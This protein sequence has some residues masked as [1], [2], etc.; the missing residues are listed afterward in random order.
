MNIYKKIS[1]IILLLLGFCFG[2][3][4]KMITKTGKTTFEASVPSFE[5]IKATNSATTAII[6]ADTG[7]VAAVVL[8]NGF[9]FKSALM[10]EHFNEN[11]MDSSKFPKATFKGKIANFAAIK[12][13]GG[14]A[15][16]V[17][18]LDM[19][20]K[21][22]NITSEAMLTKSGAGYNLDGGFSVKPQ[23]FDI[24]I[25]TLVSK[26]IAKDIKVDYQYQLK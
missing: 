5:E 11:Y 24:E 13:K 6:N 18:V 3:S 12:D 14:K 23:D 22:K 15:A 10:E 16:I 2:F 4:Q 1:A 17:G 21:Q 8:M 25:P 20:G 26:K 19:H 7:E 9:K